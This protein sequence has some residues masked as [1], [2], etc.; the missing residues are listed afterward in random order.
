MVSS[1]YSE[2]E[3]K[4]M[5]VSSNKRLAKDFYDKLCIV[6]EHTPDERPYEIETRLRGLM[7][8]V[9]ERYLI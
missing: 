9:Y 3:I 5:V 6:L 4:D 7:K 8:E 1:N 2:K